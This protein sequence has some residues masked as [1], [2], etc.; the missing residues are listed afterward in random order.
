MSALFTK[1][2]NCTENV[3]VEQVLKMPSN[4]KPFLLTISIARFC[5][6]FVTLDNVKLYKMYG[7]S[8]VKRTLVPKEKKDW[9]VAWKDYNPV[10]VS[11]DFTNK[12]W[13]DP[14]IRS[15]KRQLN[16]VFYK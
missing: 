11:V 13:A 1:E 14:Q 4:Y 3:R 2:G 5:L 7:N 15:V 8:V 16:F 9:S 10:P 12:P 6:I